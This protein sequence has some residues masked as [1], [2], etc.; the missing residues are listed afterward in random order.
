MSKVGTVEVYTKGKVSGK[1]LLLDLDDTLWDGMLL[2][3][4]INNEDIFNIRVSGNMLRIGD[5]ILPLNTGVISLVKELRDKGYSV[6]IVSHNPPEL[7]L[8]IE[9]ILSEIGLEYDAIVLS[10]EL[11]K[12]E[13]VKY[14]LESP[15]EGV[16]FIDDN[17]HNLY[18]V[19]ST[20]TDIDILI[21]ERY[22]GITPLSLNLFK[23]AK[24]IQEE[25]KSLYTRLE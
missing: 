1:V 7:G 12:G 22:I 13:M 23:L 18:D 25:L 20:I 15:I 11:G 21:G 10:E 4:L 2:T 3:C 19:G 8:I 5:C 6:G 16:V 17:P 9:D 24:S 14:I